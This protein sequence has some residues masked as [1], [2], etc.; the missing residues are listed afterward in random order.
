MQKLQPLVDKM[1][2][3][4]ETII[5]NAVFDG[6]RQMEQMVKNITNN[7]AINNISN[8][9]RPSVVIGDINVTCPGVT[10]QQVAEQLGGVLDKELDK[11]FSGFHIYTDQMSRVR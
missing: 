4:E 9:N 7:T 8:N 6:Q 10:S 5:S 1:L 3:G 2:K 11:K